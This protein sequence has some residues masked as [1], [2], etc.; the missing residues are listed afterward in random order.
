[1]KEIEQVMKKYDIAG[2]VCLHT[3]GFGEYLNKIDTSYSCAR[4]QQ[5]GLHL[6]AKADDLGG[7]EKRN[8][9]MTTTANMF[10]ILAENVGRQAMILM[11]CHEMVDKV[12][13]SEHGP[14]KHTSPEEQQN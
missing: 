12:M 10:A 3:P 7:A 14:G 5:G 8:K 2:V 6:K 9:I 13:D 1:M 4:Y 11:D